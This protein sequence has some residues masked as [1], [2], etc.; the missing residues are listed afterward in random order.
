MYDIYKIS[1]FY[2]FMGFVCLI[3]YFNIPSD[4]SSSFYKQIILILGAIYLVL[5][6]SRLYNYYKE[7]DN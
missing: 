7:K 2:I 4:T 5:G 3:I 6:G 1:I